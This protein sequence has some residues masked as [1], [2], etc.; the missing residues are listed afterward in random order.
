MILGEQLYT[1]LRMLTYGLEGVITATQNYQRIHTAEVKANKDWP[2]DK[3]S[4]F[5]PQDYDKVNGKPQSNF[6]GNHGLRLQMAG[7]RFFAGL[8]LHERYKHWTSFVFDRVA[9]HYYHFDS[10]VFDRKVRLQQAVLLWRETLANIGQPFDF[11]FYQLPITPQLG[12]WECGLICIYELFLTLRGLVGVSASQ[13][14]TIH[15]YEQV[16]IDGL[17]QTEDIP[18]FQ[19]RLRDWV[20]ALGHPTPMHRTKT[21]R[22]FSFIRAFFQC[23]ILEELG[24]ADGIY[25]QEYDLNNKEGTL[26][27]RE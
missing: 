14:R 21:H 9:G 7:C 10:Y 6:G 5:L 25:S 26:K 1:L 20:L 15:P 12:G 18:D 24:I 27:V 11:T 3:Q 19:L 17:L 23:L 22:T 16:Y 4:P 2:V 8:I 13:A